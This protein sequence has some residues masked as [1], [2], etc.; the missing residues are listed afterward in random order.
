[1]GLIVRVVFTE[2]EKERVFW[3]SGKACTMAQKKRFY[4]A[5]HIGN[6]S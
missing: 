6:S 1:M 3:A 4:E 5:Y 2:L